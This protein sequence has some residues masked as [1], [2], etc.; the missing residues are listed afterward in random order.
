MAPRS[1]PGGS[2]LANKV[3]N[4]VA[5]A[6]SNSQVNLSWDDVPTLTGEVFDIERDGVI[7]GNDYA[8]THTPGS[9]Y[10][11]TGL[12]PGTTY[13]Y[14]VRAVSSGGPLDVAGLTAW[15][16]FTDITTLWQDTARTS[17]I[18]ADAQIIK[19]VTDKSGVGNH[20][21]EATNGP[22]Y[23]VAIINGK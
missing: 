18:T 6:V 4:L 15:Y 23:K 5:T 9:P 14:R 11:D 8:G 19:G 20:L 7:V 3:T 16:D 17:P 22:A 12:S 1:H 10:Q 13:T 21:S 2:P